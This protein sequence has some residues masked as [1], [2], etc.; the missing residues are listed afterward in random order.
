MDRY[1]EV[2]ADGFVFNSS[3][4]FHVIGIIINFIGLARLKHH[5]L[6][7]AAKEGNYQMASS[8]IP[9]NLDARF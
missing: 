4:G 9:Y 6:S 7:V 2:Y 8:L 1:C 5:I 3:S